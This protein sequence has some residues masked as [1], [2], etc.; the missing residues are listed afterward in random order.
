MIEDKRNE[1]GIDISG[2]KRGQDA[3]MECAPGMNAI[4]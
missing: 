1:A 4:N 2:V 3:V